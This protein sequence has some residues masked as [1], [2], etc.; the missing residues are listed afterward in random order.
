M[1]GESITLHILRI[2][3]FTYLRFGRILSILPVFCL[4]M[5][6]EEEGGD[7][8]VVQRLGVALADQ[9]DRAARSGRV[10]IVQRAGQGSRLGPPTKQRKRAESTR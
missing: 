8:G 3:F 10:R 5:V 6:E 1:R 7:G 4:Q 2:P 9:E